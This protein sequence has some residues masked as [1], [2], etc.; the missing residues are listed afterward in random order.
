MKK[1]TLYIISAV[2]ILVIVVCGYIYT[3]P[4]S[5]DAQLFDGNYV[6]HIFDKYNAELVLDFY[7]SQENISRLSVSRDTASSEMLGREIKL[8]FDVK[9]EN[10][11][12]KTIKERIS[13]IGRRYW[14]ATFKWS[15]PIKA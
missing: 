6:H 7:Y 11:D 3:R 10:A 13:F 9:Y 2:L 8:E 12:G 14:I 15:K 1:K 5:W 4:V